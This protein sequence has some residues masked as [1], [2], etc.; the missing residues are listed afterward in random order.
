MNRIISYLL[1]AIAAA[2]WVSIAY[3]GYLAFIDTNGLEV[4]ESASW[5]A[6]GQPQTQF[7]AGEIL[8]AHR[9]ICVDKVVPGEF[10]IEIHDENGTVWIVSRGRTGQ[11]PEGCTQRNVQY[12]I[13]NELRPG[14]YSLK[15]F[16]LYETNALRS[17]RHELPPIK[18][19]VVP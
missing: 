9:V 5:G 8:I 10:S 1:T 12:K 11:V 3:V 15:A 18:F 16:T 17:E 6:N 2:V 7:R 13:P 4:T 14:N 19:E